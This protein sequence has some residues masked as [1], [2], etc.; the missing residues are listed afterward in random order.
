MANMARLKVFLDAVNGILE[1]AT[2]H[3]C[4]IDHNIDTVV[5]LQNLACTVAHGLED[6]EVDAVDAHDDS[7]VDSLDSV[8]DGRVL[9][10]AAAD[11]KKRRG[12]CASQGADSGVAETVRSRAGNKNCIVRVW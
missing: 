7:G 3:A 4:T 10:G 1:I 6:V 2:H 12:M 8:D 9:R 5:L 11:E